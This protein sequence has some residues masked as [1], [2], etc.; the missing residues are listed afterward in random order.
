MAVT[1]NHIDKREAMNQWAE[2]IVRL[3]AAEDRYDRLFFWQIGAKRRMLDN[4]RCLAAEC[5]AA[6][7]TYRALERAE[8]EAKAE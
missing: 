7:D 5:K 2:S 6:G 1:L 8:R 3:N 4:I